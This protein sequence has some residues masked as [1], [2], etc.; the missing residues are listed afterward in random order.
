[1]QRVYKSQF[2]HNTFQLRSFIASI[3]F[4]TSSVIRRMW[5]ADLIGLFR[6]SD[7]CLW[8]GFRSFSRIFFTG[9]RHRSYAVAWI[10]GL[11]RLTVE[12]R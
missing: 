5:K 11:L 6:E 1:M 10:L 3:R 4:T 12:R 2:S 9:Q 8:I 7:V